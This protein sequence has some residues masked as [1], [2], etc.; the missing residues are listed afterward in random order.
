MPIVFH[1]LIRTDM[2]CKL[3]LSLRLHAIVQRLLLASIHHGVLLSPSH[4]LYNEYPRDRN[5]K[6]EGCC[7]CDC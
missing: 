6:Q 2:L 3:S 7:C 5:Y 4:D 1:K